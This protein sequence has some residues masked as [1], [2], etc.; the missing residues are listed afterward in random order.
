MSSGRDPF[1]MV[2]QPTENAFKV[3]AKTDLNWGQVGVVQSGFIS[4]L[5]GF[6][7]EV[8]HEAA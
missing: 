8:M 4:N 3:A 2:G 1:A 5:E 7:A 6:L